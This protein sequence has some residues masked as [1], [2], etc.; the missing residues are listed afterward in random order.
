MRTRVLVF[1]GFAM[2]VG[3]GVSL[4]ANQLVNPNFTTNIAGWTVAG[5]PIDWIG[6]EGNAAPGALRAVAT[7]STG[8]VGMG[9]ATQCTAATAGVAYDFGAS[10]KIEP[11]STQ[12]GGA[13]LRVTYFT[14]SNCTG[15]L[16][17][18]G[19]V[20]PTS[21]AGWQSVNVQNDVAPAGTQSAFVELIQSIA[22]PG[23][24]T[25]YWDDVFFGPDPTPAELVSFAAE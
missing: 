13:R 3:A 14:N 20:D 16:T 15:T 10:F 25:A 22:G 23:T 6:T 12:T 17:S 9:V 24:F 7:S 21:V 4:A 5:W 1:V 18:G 2:V 19:S 11:A 8:S